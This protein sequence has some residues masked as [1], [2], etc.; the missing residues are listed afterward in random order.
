MEVTPKRRILYV[1]TKSSWGGAQRYVFDVACGA[2]DKGYEVMVAV[3]GEG[4]L[5]ERLKEE[6]IEVQQLRDLKRDINIS[7]ELSSLSA[8]WKIASQWKPDVIHGNSSKAGLY[9]GIVGR[10]AGTKHILFTA[11]GWAFNEDRPAWQKKIIWFFHFLTILLSHKTICVSEATKRDT[12]NMPLSRSHT[13]VIPNGVE[14]STL[15]SRKDARLI[16]APHVS[17][18]VWVGTIAELHP[19][20]QLHVLLRAFAKIAEHHADTMLMIIG[21]GQERKRLEALVRELNLE[22]RVRLRGH[23]EQASAY[24]SAFDLFVLPSRSEA[25]AYVLLEAGLAELPVIASNVGGVPEVI[26]DKE[27]GILVPSGDVEGLAQSMDDLLGD[28]IER[29]RLAAAHKERVSKFFRKADMIER[30]LA[31][32]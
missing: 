6:G 27:T 19:T 10:L 11:H 8:L 3:G 12:E 18:P 13:V 16:L 17:F 28:P 2:R 5:V 21:E 26:L 31:L 9:A 23:V 4:E 1:I 7:H 20:K 24:L 22:D 30:T 25:L 14:E 29:R 15:L 32:Y